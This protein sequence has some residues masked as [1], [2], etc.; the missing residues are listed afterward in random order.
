[1]AENRGCLQCFLVFG[2]ESVYPCLNQALHR[3]CTLASVLSA[4]W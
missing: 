4:P 2:R 1:L 3:P